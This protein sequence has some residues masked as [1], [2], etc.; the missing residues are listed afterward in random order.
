VPNRDN[1]RYR[2]IIKNG[3]FTLR[4]ADKYF[5]ILAIAKIPKLNIL[6]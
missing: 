1:Q 5:G 2:E 4:P 6:R 3:P